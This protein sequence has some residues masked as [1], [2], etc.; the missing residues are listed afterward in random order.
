[1]S[2]SPPPPVATEPSDDQDAHQLQ[3]APPA[4]GNPTVLLVT[5]V[6]L[7]VT[8]VASW[9]IFDWMRETDANRGVVVGAALLVGVGGVFAIFLL[10]DRLTDGLPLRYQESV[11]P[12]VFVGPALLLLAI[13][14]LYPAINT[15]MLSFQDA[16]GANWIGLDNYINI[17]NDPA[18]LRSVRNTVA[19]MIVVPSAGVLIGLVFAVLADRLQRGE[20]LAKSMIFLPMAI[21]F[22][23][24]SVLWGFIYDWRPTGN[25]TGL[26]NGIMVA[27][28]REPTAWL[29]VTPWNNLFLMIIMIWMQT[30]FA[31]VILSAAIKGVPEDIIEAARIDGATEL[32]VFYRITVPSIMSAIVVVT[33]TMVINVLKVFDIVWVMTGGRDG[34]E[35]IAERMI[36]WAFSFRNAGQ[37]AAI[38]V[39]L[40]VLVLPVMVWNIKRFRAEEEIR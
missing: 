33:T 39:M 8:A 24:A 35:V 26:L 18:L 31:M 32:Q 27:I 20:S 34:T 6:L 38:A 29:A 14:L 10:L 4:R 37:G 28:G 12:W 7:I 19:W 25:Q 2:S 5:A 22:V 17:V 11:R 40:F 13:F 21:S 1:V 3:D 9:A 36:R 23:G 16:D 15:I 30:G